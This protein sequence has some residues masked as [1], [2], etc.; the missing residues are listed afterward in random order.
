[1]V[2]DSFYSPAGK[3]AY[4]F[5]RRRDVAFA[6]YRVVSG[7]GPILADAT[8]VSTAS[9]SH[10]ESYSAEAQR[11]RLEMHCIEGADQVIRVLV[12]KS[13]VANAS[14]A[15]GRCTLATMIDL[16]KGYNDIAIEYSGSVAMRF[17]ALVIN[18]VSG[19]AAGN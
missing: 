4:L 7:L 6:G 9:V 19:P 8:R 12:N 17:D 16:H 10:L 11:A 13:E 5:A 2:I 18:R 1:M 3:L 14:M 15:P